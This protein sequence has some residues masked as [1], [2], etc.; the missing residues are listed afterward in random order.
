MWWELNTACT[1]EV[2]IDHQSTS[3]IAGAEI[4]DG[5]NVWEKWEAYLHK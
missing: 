2:A 4:F 3:E 1:C 5:E